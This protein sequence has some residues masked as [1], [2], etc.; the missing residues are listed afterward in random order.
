M[1][2]SACQS[3]PCNYGGTCVSKLL[4]PVNS[5]YQCQCP[6]DRIGINC[7]HRE[8]NIRIIQNDAVKGDQ[9]SFFFELINRDIECRMSDQS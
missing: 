4:T 7:Q 6:P 1:L 3:N 5:S 8:Y 9:V 2:P